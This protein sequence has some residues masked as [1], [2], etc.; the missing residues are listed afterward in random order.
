MLLLCGQIGT[1]IT[2]SAEGSDAREAIE[3]IAA[4]VADRFGEA[5]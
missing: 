5:R 2:V 3:A 1:R 4:L